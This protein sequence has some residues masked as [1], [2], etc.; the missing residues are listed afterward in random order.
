MTV[1]KKLLYGRKSHF[2][3]ST[4]SVFGNLQSVMITIQYDKIENEGDKH[5]KT[6][7]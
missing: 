4:L 1:S 5:D 3:Y 6:N 2:I 7:C